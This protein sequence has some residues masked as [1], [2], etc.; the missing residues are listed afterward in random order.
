M[1]N[2]REILTGMTASIAGLPLAT[3]LGDPK[4][5]HAAA[6]LLERHSM[7]LTHGKTVS[8]YLGL[9]KR[10]P[11]PAVVLFHEW[12]GVNDQIKAVAQE[13]AEKGYVALAVDLFDGRV[14]TVRNDAKRL[15]G[16]VGRA[17]ALEISRKWLQWLKSQ[18]SVNGKLATIGWCF[19]GGW[20]LSAAT[21]E[22]VDATVVYYGRVNHPTGELRHLK[23]PVMGH[24][25]T[26][27]MWINR[28][29]VTLFE[30]GMLKAQKR[31]ISHWYEAGHAFAN[32]TG[33]RYDNK[34]AALAWQRTMAFLETEFNRK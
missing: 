33:S 4:L 11:A 15:M 27:D 16:R 10:T 2:R 34:D 29:M 3:I 25:A 26:H 7:K 19:G 5:A 12:W 30:L 20:A 21:V 13:F 18:E 6:S 31:S 24:F 14:A 32:P 9:P 23:G 17:E 22:P 8:A 28:D 1:H